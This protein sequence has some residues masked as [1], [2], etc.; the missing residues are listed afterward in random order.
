M[1]LAGSHEAL[2]AGLGGRFATD[3]GHGL[4]A[5]QVPGLGPPAS[6]V[7]ASAMVPGV[8]VERGETEQ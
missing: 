7:S 4:Q 6:H 2:E 1:R 8:A 3:D 5:R